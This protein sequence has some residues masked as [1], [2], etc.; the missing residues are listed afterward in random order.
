MLKSTF[1]TFIISVLPLHA[2]YP[3]VNL[4]AIKSPQQMWGW[5]VFQHRHTTNSM[6]N[7]GNYKSYRQNV[8]LV[9]VLYKHFNISLSYIQKYVSYVTNVA[10]HF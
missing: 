5:G 1:E 2:G 9:A 4:C 8:R 6:L 3:S 10:V 7:K